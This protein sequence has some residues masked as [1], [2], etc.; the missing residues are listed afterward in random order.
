MTSFF[1]N[2]FD[3]LID[4]RGS[5]RFNDRPKMLRVISFAFICIFMGLALQGCSSAEKNDST[6]EALLKR[7][8]EYEN[9]DRYEEAIR[10]YQ[11]LRTKFP[12]SPQAL[13]AELAVA[14]VYF[15][16]ESYPEAQAA[17]QSF[18]DLHPHHPQIAYV[19]YRY[20]LSLYHQLPDTIDRD[21]SLA[22]DAILAFNEVIKKFPGSEYVKDSQEKKSALIKMLAE[23]EIYIGDFYFKRHFYES[24]LPRYEKT[25]QDYSGIGFDEKALSHAAFCA[26]KIGDPNKARKYI[27]EL[28]QKDIK[29]T[30]ETKSLLKRIRL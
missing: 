14:D 8:Q 10:R 28:K 15:K 21:I 27:S 18:R 3:E 26:F 11:T 30:S 20:A 5:P 17:Y 13:Q 19:Y 23:K 6:P 7:A 1:M 22:P 16:Q 4:R 9:D 25:I 12:Y 29:L 2:A 24:A